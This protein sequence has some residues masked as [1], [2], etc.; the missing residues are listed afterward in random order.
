MSIF[1][2][3]ADK[4]SDEDKKDLIELIIPENINDKST[5]FDLYAQKLKFPDYFGWNWDA[6]L[7]C[8]VTIV[9]TEKERVNVIHKDLPFKADEEQRAIYLYAL[10]QILQECNT[11]Q[12]NKIV[13]SFPE[14]ARKTISGIETKDEV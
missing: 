14:Q 6:F 11:A 13:I 2:Y 7:D 3:S 12:H 4:I 10:H 8:M 1:Q 9:L 5:L